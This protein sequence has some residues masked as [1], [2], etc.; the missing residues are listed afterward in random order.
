MI[1]T[2]IP[3]LWHA[4]RVELAVTAADVHGKRAAHVDPARGSSLFLTSNAVLVAQNLGAAP[5]TNVAVRVDGVD[6]DVLLL[7]PPLDVGLSGPNELVT[8]DALEFNS[9]PNMI[10]EDFPISIL[11]AEYALLFH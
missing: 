1:P 2:R 10:R 6:A 8:I 9:D 5:Q 11:A 3:L 4:I 7:A